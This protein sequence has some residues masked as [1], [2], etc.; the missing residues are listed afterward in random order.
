MGRRL[1][2]LQIGFHNCGKVLWN[3]GWWMLITR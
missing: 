3:Q 2:F 1:L